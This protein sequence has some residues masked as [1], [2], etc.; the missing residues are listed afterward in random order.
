MIT[1]QSP[2][3]GD[4]ELDQ[5]PS[6][7]SSRT[8]REGLYFVDS[9]LSKIAEEID[10]EMVERWQSDSE[11]TLIFVSLHAYIHTLIFINWSVVG[12]FILCGR[13]PSTF[14]DN[15]GLDSTSASG[16]LE[17]LSHE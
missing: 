11:S 9:S 15:P 13:G 12:W 6:A 7:V 8:H 3:I 4:G 17:I 5:S 2:C 1:P 10:K 14:R 16:E